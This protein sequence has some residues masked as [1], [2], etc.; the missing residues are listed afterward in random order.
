MR[1][2][3]RVRGFTLVELLVV[4]AIIGILVALLLP[5]IQA[6]REAARRTQCSNN[7]KQI[8]LAMQNYHDTFNTLPN[9]YFNWGGEPRW[10]WSAVIL[11]FMEESALYDQL[12]PNR[13]QGSQVRNADPALLETAIDGYLCPSDINRS[14]GPITNAPTNSHFRWTGPTQQIGKNNY[15][16][17]E[18]VCAYSTDHGSHNLSEILDGTST[19]ILVGERDEVER[20]AALWPGRR[21]STSSV[22]FRGLNPIGWPSLKSLGGE[23]TAGPPGSML[24]INGQCSRYNVGSTHPGGAQFAFCDGSV[25]FLSDDTESGI[26]NGCGDSTGCATVHK[27][28]PTNNTVFQNLCNR[29][30]GNSV[31][32]P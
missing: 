20:V 23:P 11:P 9:S 30:D 5:A 1:I 32:I 28:Y 13:L 8:G 3:H 12:E 2:R 6:A 29:Q 18:A 15:V 25:H 14:K 7:L 22:A 21:K 4:I 26:A 31:A 24:G 27:W 10:A 17:N 16:V 19:T